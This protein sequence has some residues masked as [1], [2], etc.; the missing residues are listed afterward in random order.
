[1]DAWERSG[2]GAKSGWLS[3]IEIDEASDPIGAD[4]SEVSIQDA[5]RASI[6]GHPQSEAPSLPAYCWLLR[7][8]GTEMA[9]QKCRDRNVGTEMSGTAGGF[10]LLT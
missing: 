2:Q 10:N 6:W 8:V 7:N 5:R 9:G 1:M 4:L 3:P